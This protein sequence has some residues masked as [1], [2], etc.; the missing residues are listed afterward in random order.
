MTTLEYGRITL[1]PPVFR[2][3]IVPRAEAAAR[4]EA[5]ARSI[6]EMGGHR[7]I[8]EALG[9]EA[10]DGMTVRTAQGLIQNNDVVEHA[11]MPSCRA[12]ATPAGARNTMSWRTTT[13]A[14]SKAGGQEGYV[15]RERLLEVLRLHS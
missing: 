15:T 1:Q 12:A 4:H 6:D 13:M 8:R 7:R 14:S 9:L 10:V 11:H 3:R 5:H 2:R